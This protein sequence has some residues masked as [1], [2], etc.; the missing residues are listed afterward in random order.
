MERHLRQ[1]EEEPELEVL[2]G[3]FGPYIAYKGT[4]YKLP[5]TLAERAAELTLEECMAVV[6]DQEGKPK[7]VRKRTYGTRK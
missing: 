2:K 6:K 4:N 1:F 3:R 7:A 5:K